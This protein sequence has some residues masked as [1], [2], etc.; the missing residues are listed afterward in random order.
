MVHCCES[1]V[2]YSR[3]YSNHVQS[4]WWHTE[5]QIETKSDEI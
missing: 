2:Y 3:Q 5:S 1:K 4:M